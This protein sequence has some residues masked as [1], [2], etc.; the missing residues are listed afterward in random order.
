LRSSV[1]DSEFGQHVVAEL[2]AATGA[3]RAARG[4]LT[5]PL[6]PIDSTAKLH[7]LQRLEK[8]R[9]KLRA[10]SLGVLSSPVISRKRDQSLI[11][12]LETV[13]KQAG[14]PPKK[15]RRGFFD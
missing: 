12:T 2:G 3:Q 6:Q 4:P 5:H 11:N 10:Q 9:E 1:I 8:A 7:A 15:H 13:L 14:P